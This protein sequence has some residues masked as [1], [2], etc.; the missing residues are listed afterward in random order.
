[1]QGLFA[2]T[3]LIEDRK[4]ITDMHIK[5]VVDFHGHVC[6]ELVLGGKLCEMI[7]ESVALNI[8]SENDY[9]IFA[10]NTTSSL[11]AIQV[12][13]GVTIG[14]QRLMVMDYGKHHYTVSEKNK[15]NSLLFKLKELSF[16]DEEL[17]HQLEE[18]ISANDAFLDDLIS[19][20]QMIDTRVMQILD[21]PPQD[22]FSVEG[23][24]KPISGGQSS[25]RYLVCSHCG[26][27]VLA[28]R[29]ISPA[30][31]DGPLCPPCHQ[32][33]SSKYILH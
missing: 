33:I 6:P 20:Q 16:E 21:T 2:I 4:M 29:C 18:K 8:I 13:L 14:N 28:S 1:M 22:L 5:R 3:L 10:E 32:M 30:E 25:S 26:E 12:L 15:N 17:F 31:S 27:K 9:T 24:P 7:K 19:Y 23:V 11:D